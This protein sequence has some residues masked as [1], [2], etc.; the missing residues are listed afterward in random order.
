MKRL[1]TV[2]EVKEVCRDRTVPSSLA[3]PS[4]IK[5]EAKKEKHKKYLVHKTFSLYK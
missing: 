5:R 1:M 2:D 4:V 3:T